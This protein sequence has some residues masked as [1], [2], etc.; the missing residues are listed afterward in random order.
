MTSAR[1]P[2]P[3]TLTFGGEAADD[4]NDISRRDTDHERP[5]DVDE[6]STKAQD[7]LESDMSDLEPVKEF[8]EGG[9][10]WYVGLENMPNRF[11]M[12]FEWVILSVSLKDCCYDRLSH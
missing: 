3:T 8:K 7:P 11:I 9:Y 6:K 12:V 5:V 1:Q 2:E 4:A 10:G